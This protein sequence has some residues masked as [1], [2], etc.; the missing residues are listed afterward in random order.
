MLKVNH[1]ES[2]YGQ[3]IALHDI[4]VEVNQGEIVTLLGVNGAGKSTTLKTISGLLHPVK[5]TIEFEGE[6]IDRVQPENIVRRRIVHVPEGRK[7]FPGLTVR[8]NLMM[9]TSNQ[10]L[11]RPEVEQGIERVL[12]VFPD[13]KRLDKQ[14][15]WSLSGGQQQMLA[16]GRGLMGNPRILMLDEPSL[17]LAPVI[18]KQVFQTIKAINEQGVTILL[19]EQN[20]SLSLRIS[21]RAYLLETG[22]VIRSDTAETLLQ[23]E[24][25]RAALMGARGSASTGS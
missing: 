10:K 23:D 8:E 15:G 18:V 7:I 19:V 25:V 20:A 6:R 14:L 22:R 11:K 3:V 12:E 24:T 4:D 1:I 9:G 5:G 2:H 16:I 13:L 21:N 17:G